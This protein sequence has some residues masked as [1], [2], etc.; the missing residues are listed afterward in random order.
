MNTEFKGENRLDLTADA[1]VPRGFHLVGEPIVP[2]SADQPYIYRLRG[3][4][5]PTCRCGRP[6]RHKGYDAETTIEDVGNR[7][8]RVRLGRGHCPACQVKFR[9]R[10][11]DIDPN[12][13]ITTRLAAHVIALLRNHPAADV[14]EIVGRSSTWCRN[15]RRRLLRCFRDAYV[16]EAGSI[17]CIDEHHARKQPHVVISDFASGAILAIERGKDE[18]AA[19]K[20]LLRLRGRDRVRYVVTDFWAPYAEAARTVLGAENVRVVYDRWHVQQ[21]VIRAFIKA[22]NALH[23]RIKARKNTR[24]IRIN[25]AE[26]RRLLLTP[27]SEL[28]AQDRASGSSQV[29]ALREVLEGYQSIRLPWEL[30]ERF[31]VV[32]ATARSPSEGRGRFM[33]WLADA[34]QCPTYLST[35]NTIRAHLD[36]ICLYFQ[37]RATNGHA[38]NNNRRIKGLLRSLRRLDDDGLTDLALLRFGQWPTERLVACYLTDVRDP[39]PEPIKWANVAAAQMLRRGKRRPR[40]VDPRQYWLPLWGR[41]TAGG[42]L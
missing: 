26:Q 4:L 3:T 14:A 31:L 23:S 16:P 38:E 12:A 13:A 30:K 29:D 5:P 8:F 22:L 18:R 40:F 7:V 28:E 21:Q 37:V 41:E 25:L 33:D 11:A 10:S 15:F 6:I 27:L 19:V 17:L 34:E 35:A 9:T 42:P 1:I 2:L 39:P 20:A 32:Y 24:P 36:G